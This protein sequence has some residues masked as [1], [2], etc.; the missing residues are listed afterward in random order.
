MNKY[1]IQVTVIKKWFDE[2][3]NLTNVYVTV[4]ADMDEALSIA[5]RYANHQALEEHADIIKHISVTEIG[6]AINEG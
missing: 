1:R 4:A 6:E 5:S 2:R 3:Y